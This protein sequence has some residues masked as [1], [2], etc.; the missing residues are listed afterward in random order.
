L[1]AVEPSEIE[2]KKNRIDK[3][4]NQTNLLAMNA[5]LNQIPN[6]IAI[7]VDPIQD[8]VFDRII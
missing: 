1:Y 8:N 4:F 7:V 6:R 2:K 5:F 3:N